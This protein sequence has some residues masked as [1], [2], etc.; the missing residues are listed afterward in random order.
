PDPG[1][2]PNRSNES[3]RSC[4]IGPGGDQAARAECRS[5]GHKQRDTRGEVLPRH[6]GVGW[7]LGNQAW[8][9]LKSNGEASWEDCTPRSVNPGLFSCIIVSGQGIVMLSLDAGRVSAGQ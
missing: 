1:L 9:I 3:S 4:A 2:G 6:T 5:P 8:F 7:F